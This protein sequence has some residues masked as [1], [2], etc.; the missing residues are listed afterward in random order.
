MRICVKI[1]QASSYFHPHVGGIETHVRELSYTLQELGHEVI[2]LCAAIPPSK[3]YELVNGIAVHRFPALDFPYVPYMRSLPR[4]IRRFS[5]DVVHSHYPPPF[6]AH[7]VVRGLPRLPHVLT[8]HCD[9]EVPDSIASLRI[10]NTCRALVQQA[11]ERFYVRP[12]LRNV[13]QIIA[14]TKSYAESSALLRGF[15]YR[16]IPNGVRLADFDAPIEGENDERRPKQIL[17]VGRLTSVKGINYLIEAARIILRYHDDATFLIV[18][19][20][21]E[22]S[23]LKALAKGYEHRIR[24][25]GNVSK[26][27]LVVLYKTSTVVVLPSFSRLEAFGVVLLEAMACQTPVIASR[28]PG[29]LDV[30]GVGGL[31]VTPRDPQSIANAV[32]EMLENPKKARL[33]G[34]RGRKLVEDKYD[35]KVVAKQILEA[36]ANVA[37]SSG[38]PSGGL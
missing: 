4:R 26:G 19:S 38:R 13:D 21:E 33:I 35:W 1:I 7:G 17:F 28:I 24:F 37:E 34:K 8:Y 18:G 3:S 23:K 12:I 20:G 15:Q 36:Y 32:I 25:C 22:Q 2:V 29:V 11:N 27:A 5:A 10:P 16:I 31:L 14:T 9:A 6:I 30:V